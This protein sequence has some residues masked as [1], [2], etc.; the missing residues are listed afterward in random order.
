M[1]RTIQLQNPLDAKPR[2]IMAGARPDQSFQGILQLM[3][4]VPLTA[5]GEVVVQPMPKTILLGGGPKNGELWTLR[6][7]ETEVIPHLDACGRA[8][9]HYCRQDPPLKDIQSGREVFKYL[10]APKEG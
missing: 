9:G 1:N 10:R 2:Y 7:P 6:D 4:L 3:V 8:I 5:D